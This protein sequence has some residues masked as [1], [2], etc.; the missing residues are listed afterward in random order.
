[1]FD[2]VVKGGVLVGPE[3][4]DP[5]TI[6]ISDGT[7]VAIL[8]PGEPAPG[9]CEI[10]ATGKFVLPG[11][12][13][14][15]VHLREPGFEH[16]ETFATGTMAA[17][18][19]GVTTVMDMPTDDPWTAT[20]ADF[21]DKRALLEGKAYVDV[22]LQAALGPNLDEL[23]TLVDLGAV[24]FEIFLA[25]GGAD[26]TVEADDDLLELMRRIQAVDSVAGITP[27]ST[28]IIERLIGQAKAH[29]KSDI[30]ALNGTRPP[31]SEALGVARACV[32]AA[33]TGARTHFRQISCGDSVAVLGRFAEIEGI[34]SEVTPHNLL[35]TDA[36]A[37]RLGPFGAVMPPLRS[38]AETRILRAALRAGSIDIVATDH[39]P[40]TRE[41]KARGLA[42]IWLA[43]TGL[44]GLQT[45]STV[46]L[47]LVDRGDLS[48]S[49]VVRTCAEQPARRF[50][51]YPRKGALTVG[52]DA[53]LVVIDA[54]AV[55]V[56]RDED[57]YSLAG[58]TAFA[59]REVKGSV[60][61]VLLRGE[62]IMHDGQLVGGP[63][64]RF[65]RP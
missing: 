34:S 22:A 64:G 63:T 7:V 58:Y 41:E 37:E 45:F 32:V 28:A 8:P 31:I 35:L 4:T 11:L 9:R 44:P 2:V 19:G 27:G 25:G 47:E 33:E 5:Q 60:T 39:A 10:D 57:Q 21:E 24:S 12:V 56:I 3:R 53:D 48:L 29:A 46:M 36:D 1:M 13:D 55:S 42:D 52:S 18:A 65:I 49:D 43:P 16:K 38:D 15:H 14:A 30:H 17:A 61:R 59:G 54:S 62:T 51:L 20:A 50:G 40:H 6:G 23:E 26:F